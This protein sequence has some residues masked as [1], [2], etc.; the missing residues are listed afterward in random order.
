MLRAMSY[1]IPV[2]LDESIEG[3]VTD[4]DGIDVDVTFGGGGHSK[5]IVEKL[6]NGQLYAFDQDQDAKINAKNLAERSFKL[7]EANFRYLKK[8]LKLYKVEQANGVL[9]DLGISSHQIDESTR[10]FSTRLDGVLD[11]RMNNR[12][13]KSAQNIL[14]EYEEKDLIH[15][16]SMYGEVKNARTLAAAIITER[17]ANPFKTTRQLKQLTDK[18]AKRGQEAKYAAQVFQAIRIEVND[19]MGALQELLQASAEVLKEDGRLVV[20]TYH[21][22]EDRLVKNFLNYGNFSGRP[23]KD[24]YGNLIRPFEPINRKP[25]VASETEVQRNKRARSAKLRIAK[26]AASP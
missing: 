18:L 26:R 1:H 23:E 24:F 19:E 15:V 9:A 22:L 4:P 25:L 2:L 13:G 6:V 3:L 21:S 7:I 10:G 16:L 20:I 14:N 5:K 12:L 8:Y 11:M 17:H